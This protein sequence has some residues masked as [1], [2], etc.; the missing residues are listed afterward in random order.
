MGVAPRGR[1]AQWAL[2]THWKNGLGGRIAQWVV[3][4][5]WNNGEG[6]LHSG[7][8]QLI[9]RMGREGCTVGCVY[10]LGLH[11]SLFILIGLNGW[12]WEGCT[13]GCVYSLEEWVWGEGCRVGCGYS[14]EEW[15]SGE[16]WRVDCVYSL[17]NGFGGGLRGRVAQ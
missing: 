2:S 16:G 14:L 7:L 5:H 6:G 4:T 3:S 8:C 1:V 9:G 17:E 10:S 13:V 15:V 11:R 12:G